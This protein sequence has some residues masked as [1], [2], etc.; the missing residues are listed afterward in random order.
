MKG[1]KTGGRQKG[2]PNKTP[3]TIKELLREI[4][5]A[6]AKQ[7]KADFALLT[8][9]DRLIF[10]TKILPYVCPRE[11]EQIEVTELREQPLFG[12]YPDTVQ[13]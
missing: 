12:D 6:N 3:A 7:I 11:V 8:P 2:T 1:Q 5:T 10:L 9:R 13:I 4:W